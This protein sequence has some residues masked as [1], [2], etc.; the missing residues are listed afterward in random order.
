[1]GVAA[2]DGGADAQVQGVLRLADLG[3]YKAKREGRN[4]VEHI[5]PVEAKEKPA[6]LR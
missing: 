2:V 6:L 4:R 1:M 3:L 5:D